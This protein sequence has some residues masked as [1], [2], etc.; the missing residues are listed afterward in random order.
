MEKREDTNIISIVLSVIVTCY[1]YTR[2]ERKIMRRTSGRRRGA[3]GKRVES[4]CATVSWS[5]RPSACRRSLRC[6]S[7]R[8]SRPGNKYTGTI[9]SYTT[10]RYQLGKHMQLKFLFTLY[11]SNTYSIVHIMQATRT[12]NE[13][14]VEQTCGIPM[15]GSEGSSRSE[16]QARG[17]VDASA[18]EGS[19]Q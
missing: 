7:T 15:S 13:N 3:A 17:R 12:S 16:R 2:S 8:Y 5:R 9:T 6:I 10:N 4:N 14:C 18:Y 11:C 19:R 1:Q